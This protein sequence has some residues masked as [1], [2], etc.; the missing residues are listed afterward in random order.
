MKL[1]K[2]WFPILLLSTVALACS[3]NFGSETPEPVLMQETPTVVHIPSITPTLSPTPHPT[4][5]P[6]VR[7]ED[8]DRAFLFGDWDRAL[9]EYGA[10]Y[11]RGKNAVGDSE[12]VPAALLGLGRTQLNMGRYETAL[13]TLNLLVNNYPGASQLAPAHFAAA[14]AYETLSYFDEAAES[15]QQYIENRPGLI[16][17]YVLEWRGDALAAA[18]NPLVA[19][20][21]YQSAMAEPR[22]DSTLPI[23]LKIAN[24]YAALGDYDTALLAYKDVYTRSTNDYTK[25]HVDIQVGNIYLDLGMMDDAYGFYLDAIENYPLSYDTYQALVYLVESGSPVNDFNRGLVDYFAGQY[26]LAIAA[27]D[28]YLNTSAEHAGTVYYYRGLA[29]R[30]LDDPVS[31]VDS[32]GILIQSYLASGFWD[33]AWEET[34]YTQ[35][36]YLEQYT[37]AADTML[38]FVEDNPTHSRAAEFLFDAAQITERNREYSKAAE[39]WE[40]IPPE[41]PSSEYAPRAIFLAGISYYRVEEFDSALAS[42]E[43]LLN[44]T[45]DP[46][47]KASAY[48]WMAKTFQALGSDDN[49]DVFF[50]NAVNADPTGYYSERARDKLLGLD[51]FEP[52]VMFDLAFDLDAERENAETWM[53]SVFAIPEAIDL[54]I[55]GLLFNDMRFVRGTELWNLGLYEM[56]RLEF[57]ALR[58]DIKLSPM[59]NYRLANYL[60][61]LGLYRTAIFS[62]RQVLDINDMEDAET[63][64]APKFFNHLRFGSYYKELVLPAGENYGFHPLLLFSILRQESLF[65][66]FVRSSAGAQGLMQIM[67]AT[68]Q[69]VITKG[70]WPPDYNVEGLYRPVV[71]IA[72][73]VDY[74]DS[75]RQYF[76]GDM[77]AALAAYNA[78]PGNAQI[79]H[80]LAGGDKDLFLEVIR[81]EETRNYIKGIYE[82]FSIYRRLYDRSP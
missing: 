47:T 45:A 2:I 39:I 68:A 1:W 63:L 60:M 42:F 43:W 53:R 56:A 6:P 12:N 79:W 24:A 4:M 67:P 77:Y 59:D 71:N 11:E 5:V 18:G 23:E 7:I 10:V 48:F 32:W 9:L 37:A 46:G 8:A 3:W 13:E 65:E 55:P 14:Q 31:A 30:A 17:S 54:S 74:L 80:N 69:D 15:Y 72:L 81:F 40:R 33:E 76:D 58:A 35:W 26:S 75:L 73:G 27:F 82:V 34:A 22:L 57:E 49:A 52:P 66:G 38:K 19:I 78:G 50:N 20:D 70:V 64:T 36:A 44:S 21:E 25:A 62:A 29:F 28:R 41:Y 51:E 16:D 61:D